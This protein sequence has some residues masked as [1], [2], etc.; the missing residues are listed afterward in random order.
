[1]QTIVLA[2]TWRSY[3]VSEIKEYV[4]VVLG[5]RA[6]WRPF[7]YYIFI[8]S[9][10]CYNRV[11]SFIGNLWQVLFL[12]KHLNHLPGKKNTISTHVSKLVKLEHYI[13]RWIHVHKGR[14]ISQK[15]FPAKYFIDTN[16]IFAIIVCVKTRNPIPVTINH[17][18]QNK[19]LTGVQDQTL[20]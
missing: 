14:K 12:G 19:F 5:K 18:Q 6:R 9:L 2:P 7:F 20:F 3:H 10:T 1:M 13:T 8:I 11:R 15:P 4:N 16:N 17:T